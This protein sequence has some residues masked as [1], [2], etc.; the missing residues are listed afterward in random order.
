MCIMQCK[1]GTAVPGLPGATGNPVPLSP[2]SEDDPQEK[3]RWMHNTSAFEVA[4][5]RR[6]DDAGQ[7]P[8]RARW[9]FRISGMQPVQGRVAEMLGER[10]GADIVATEA[11]FALGEERRR[12][13]FG[14]ED[15]SRLHDGFEAGRPVYVASVES[16]LRHDRI[17]NAVDRAGVQADAYAGIRCKPERR[18]VDRAQ[19]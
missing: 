7:G 16:R 2:A 12:K 5:P 19:R 9:E 13:R 15:V 1:S 10:H 3:S 11:P 4:E 17:E 6:G 18:P 8:A 14:C